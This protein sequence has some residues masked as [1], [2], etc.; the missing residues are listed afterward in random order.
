MAAVPF[1]LWLIEIVREMY[2]AFQYRH[3]MTYLK[4]HAQFS[5]FNIKAIK[6]SMG[7]LPIQSEVNL[8][9]SSI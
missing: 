1:L 8:E 4:A 9:L 7:S 5:R 6:K 2:D 3:R